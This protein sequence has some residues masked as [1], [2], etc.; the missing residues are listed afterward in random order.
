MP[1]PWPPPIYLGT[2]P[3]SES[4]EVLWMA[5]QNN[6]SFLLACSEHL[7]DS[8]N[9]SRLVDL[10]YRDYLLPSHG[11]LS[12]LQHL[13][14]LRSCAPFPSSALAFSS[15]PLSS[16]YSSS[17]PL[18]ASRSPGIYSIWDQTIDYEIP[19]SRSKEKHQDEDEK[20]AKEKKRRHEEKEK[21]EKEEEEEEGEDEEDEDEPNEPIILSFRFREAHPENGTVESPINKKKLILCNGKGRPPTGLSCAINR[22]LQL[23]FLIPEAVRHKLISGAWWGCY[24][25]CQPRVSDRLFGTGW[26]Y[27]DL[28]DPRFENDAVLTVSIPF[29][30]LYS[31][32]YRCI[33][34]KF[35]IRLFRDGGLTLLAESSPIDSE[36]I[37]FEAPP[38]LINIPAVHR[39]ESGPLN[40]ALW[41]NLLTDYQLIKL[42]NGKLFRAERSQAKLYPETIPSGCYFLSIS[43]PCDGPTYGFTLPDPQPLVQQ[44]F[45]VIRATDKHVFCP[46]PNLQALCAPHVRRLLPS[47]PRGF[48]TAHLI[49]RVHCD[50]SSIWKVLTAFQIDLTPGFFR[51]FE[52][53][54]L[55]SI[56][57]SD[58]HVPT[59]FLIWLSKLSSLQHL[60]LDFDNKLLQES[61]AHLF[62]LS[63]HQVFF[64]L[65]SFFPRLTSL[66]IS[67]LSLG[68]PTVRKISTLYHLEFLELQLS[69][70]CPSSSS[71]P[72]SFRSS[73]LPICP[74]L[75]SSSSGFEPNSCKWPSLKSLTLSD[76]EDFSIVLPLF[77][78]AKLIKLALRN[79]TTDAKEVLR[80]FQNLKEFC[81]HG[82][83]IP[84]E[85]FIQVIGRPLETLKLS[86]CEIQGI[87][88]QSLSIGAN[89]RAINLR[90]T[91]MAPQLAML[92]KTSIAEQSPSCSFQNL[93]I[94][95][96]HCKKEYTN[97]E[98]LMCSVISH[99]DTFRKSDADW[100]GFARQSS[101][102]SQ[103]QLW[104]WYR[105]DQIYSF[106]PQPPGQYEFRF[107]VSPDHTFPGCFS[108]SH[109][110]P[111]HG[112]STALVSSLPFT[113]VAG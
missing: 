9:S 80:V 16:S 2:F 109:S 18:S 69:S 39:A 113:V 97:E 7:K 22:P 63:I 51:S 8:P 30:K 92:L 25:V 26:S 95:W 14:Y 3:T 72:S 49:D 42:H 54:S 50:V 74:P 77:Q 111:R 87:V 46:I 112:A 66:T 83:C 34:K 70:F 10:S 29:W 99:A 59:F 41:P 91:W 47:L 110:F 89:F 71:S 81:W 58:Q 75:P 44:Y 33:S 88:P 78:E 90:A 68:L 15:S 64:Q 108:P 20:E 85:L 79:C 23:N 96:T 48:F 103:F 104:K 107:Y 55:T 100:V 45:T 31:L 73:S 1:I 60:Q 65:L 76:T 24:S 84:V 43:S 102:S 94:S 32:R 17:S 98:P 5:L 86:Y 19:K 38:S 6:M 82:N 67:N 28:S 21:E 36:S 61:V 12:S 101:E 56:S 93:F 35:T 105:R 40:L 11:T 62:P 13:V 53:A 52:G 4:I 27:L 57:I 37:D 106:D